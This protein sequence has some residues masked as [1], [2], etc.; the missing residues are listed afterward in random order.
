ME[1]SRANPPIFQIILISLKEM[2]S[3]KA[4]GLSEPTV[5][6]STFRTS[7]FLDACDC[8]QS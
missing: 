2:Y 4:K 6:R 1:V 5:W 7:A 8:K 3:Y